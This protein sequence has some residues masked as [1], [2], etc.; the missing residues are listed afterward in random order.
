MVT[1][2]VEGVPGDPITQTFMDW[3]G[4]T[5][6]DLKSRLTRQYGGRKVTIIEFKQ[7]P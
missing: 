4:T 5:R 6:K 2:T 7:T 1:F 3:I